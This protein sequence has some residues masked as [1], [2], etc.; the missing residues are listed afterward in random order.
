M[1]D[2]NGDNPIGSEDGP[3]PEPEDAEYVDTG[4]KDDTYQHLDDPPDE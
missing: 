4:D 3:P 1:T 2:L